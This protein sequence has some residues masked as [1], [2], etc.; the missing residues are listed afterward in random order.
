M[1]ACQANVKR[2]VTYRCTVTIGRLRSGKHIGTHNT[3][4]SMW[5]HVHKRKDLE[6]QHK[7]VSIKPIMCVLAL[8]PFVFMSLIR[9]P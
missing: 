9:V 7:S 6:R 4:T 3:L 2:A 8:N 5:A 1:C